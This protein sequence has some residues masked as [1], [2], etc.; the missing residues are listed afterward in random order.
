MNGYNCYKLCPIV[1]M[2]FSRFN[3]L[4]F[5]LPSLPL[6]LV[7]SRSFFRVLYRADKEGIYRGIALS[8][9]RGYHRTS[10][11]VLQLFQNYA[12]DNPLIEN[13]SSLNST[14]MKIVSILVPSRIFCWQQHILIYFK[15]F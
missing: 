6:S 15:I 11:V 13:N 1:L 8:F 12:P 5:S 2:F 3:W 10:K 9:L 4:S 7:Q 14:N